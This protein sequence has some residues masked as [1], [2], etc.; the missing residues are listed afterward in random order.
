M[1]FWA[2]LIGYQIVWFGAV[3]GAS[4]G[5]P[6][7]GVAL[8]TGFVGAQLWASDSRRADLR[9]VAVALYLGMGLDGLLAASG[10][11][12][13]VTP[14][15]ALPTGGAPVWILAL[16]AA[17]AMTFNH[18]LTYLRDRPVLGALLGLIGGPLAYWGAARAWGAMVFVAPVWRS[19]AW[20][21]VGWAVA[22]LVL[23]QL[24]RRWERNLR[25]PAGSVTRGAS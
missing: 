22:M 3:I 4:R 12:Q 6:W 11:A 21:S 10:W 23:C 5:S 15:P 7:W 20:L 16:W 9:L 17:F 14:R 19:V 13:Y 25:R 2:N 24:A 1:R 18:S 8:A